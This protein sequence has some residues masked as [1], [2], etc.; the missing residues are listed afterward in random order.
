M[1]LIPIPPSPALDNSKRPTML[2]VLFPVAQPIKD[3]ECEDYFGR[4]EIVY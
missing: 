3:G 1:P 4:E 2:K